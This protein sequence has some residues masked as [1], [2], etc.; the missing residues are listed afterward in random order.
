MRT[1]LEIISELKT[2]L[3]WSQPNIKHDEMLSLVSELET[4]LTVDEIIDNP[5]EYEELIEEDIE[6]FDETL[7]DFLETEVIE[8]PVVVEPIPEKSTVVKR[9][10]NKK[11]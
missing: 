7:A 4:T 10:Y 11:K 3:Y 8:E 1:S 2:V 5:I 6:I 9:N